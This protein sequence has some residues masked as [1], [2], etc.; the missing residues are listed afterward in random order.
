MSSVYSLYLIILTLSS[1]KLMN[2]TIP[3]FLSGM[4]EFCPTSLKF[5]TINYFWHTTYFL[6]PLHGVLIFLFS[7]LTM[8]FC[9]HLAIYCSQISLG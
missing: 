4:M 9:E 6:Q 8:Y 1:I 3:E 7:L 2:K 5:Q